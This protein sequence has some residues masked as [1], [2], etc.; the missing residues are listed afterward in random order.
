MLTKVRVSAGDID[1]ERGSFLNSPQK[2]MDLASSQLPIKR[3]ISDI[4]QD[5]LKQSQHFS[6]ASPLITAVNPE[7]V[8]KDHTEAASSQNDITEKPSKMHLKLMDGFEN[9]NKKSFHWILQRLISQRKEKN[10]EQEDPSPSIVNMSPKNKESKTFKAFQLEPPE[11]RSQEK[12]PSIILPRSQNQMHE[13]A[14]SFKRTIA[15]IRGQSY[16]E[17]KRVNQINIT[18]WDYIKSY[19]WKSKSLNQK[20]V[21]IQ[22]GMARIN[23]RLDIFNV[24]RKLREVDKLKVLLFEGEQLVLFEGLPRPELRVKEEPNPMRSRKSITHDQLKNSR[25][26]TEID[27]NELIALSYESLK[28][29]NSSNIVDQKLIE[30]YEDMFD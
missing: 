20:L 10:L 26:I 8:S 24:L 28:G 11:A 2:Q 19:I 13:N 29:K 3:F 6:V 16:L 1:I 9:K 30:I 12:K 17:K 27:K 4:Q 25:S 23:E 7:F 15:N 5:S 21:L 14:E 18:F 22:E